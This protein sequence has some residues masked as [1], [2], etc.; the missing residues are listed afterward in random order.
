MKFR[1]LLDDL[2]PFSISQMAGLSH[3]V[4]FLKVLDWRVCPFMTSFVETVALA[5]PLPPAHF[6]RYTSFIHLN[7][8]LKY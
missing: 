7:I 2:C 3:V 6:M 8:Y 1:L 4:M 5:I